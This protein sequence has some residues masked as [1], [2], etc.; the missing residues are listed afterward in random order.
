MARASDDT[1]DLLVDY[2]HDEARPYDEGGV[3]SNY[4]EGYYYYYRHYG[5]ER[6]YALLRH[7]RSIMNEDTTG[8]PT[9][10]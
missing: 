5:T 8:R 7:D 10:D 1:H 3:A 6:V 9:P 2:Y 4:V